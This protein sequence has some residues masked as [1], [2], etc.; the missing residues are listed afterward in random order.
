[1]VGEE[2]IYDT[3]CL[4]LY[5]QNGQPPKMCPRKKCLAVDL[6]IIYLKLLKYFNKYS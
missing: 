3:K 6:A 2:C 5:G 4:L 1:M